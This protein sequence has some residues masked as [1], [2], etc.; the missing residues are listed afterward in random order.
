MGRTPSAML[1][2]GLVL[3]GVGMAGSTQ[4]RSADR[5]G[6]P[7]AAQSPAAFAITNVR[8]FD[9]E[10][11]I[12]RAHVV[13][14]DGRIASA[15]DAAP[16]AGIKAIDGTGHT[17]MPGLIDAHTHAFG[18]ALERA[19]LFG[20]TTELDMFTD[21]SLAAQMRREQKD[22]VVVR[23]ADL[24]SAGTL[25]TAPGGHGTEYGLKIPTI[26]NAAEAAAFV[27][28]RVAE[29]SDYIK[30]VYD[31]R[32]SSAPRFPSINQDA[33]RAVVTAARS[34]NKL[35]VV[36]IGTQRSADHAIA[37][38][39]NGLVHLF[40]D[41]PPAPD[42]AQRMR[43]AGMFAIPTLTVIESTTGTASGASLL[44]DD[45]LA[46]YLT[47][48]E[49]TNLER[50]FPARPSAARILEHAM[51]A[52]RQL[53][54]TGVPLLAGTDAP[55]PGTAHGISIHRELELLVRAGLEPTAA[56]KAA[57]SVPARAFSLVDRG[58]IAAGMRADLVLVEGDPTT[59]ITA[60]R[61]IAGVWKGGVPV[62]RRKAEE[63]AAPDG[64][65]ATGIVSRFEGGQV[66]AEFG[67]GWQVSTDSLMGGK[68]VADMKL[69]P[70][71][72]ESSKG[73]LQ[74]TGTIVEGA[75]YPWAGPM[76]FPAQTPMQP[77]NLARFKE[78][79]FHARGDG[80]EYQVMVFAT[81][82]GNIPA[83]HAFKPGPEWQEVVI[84]FSAFGID[85]S[86]LSGVLFSAGAAAGSFSFAIDEVRF[87]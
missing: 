35:A 21:H 5:S 57:T 20:V 16:P 60:T 14:R 50:G 43:A 46:P 49:R 48:A 84:P 64:G 59:E 32:G 27:D 23:R 63:T 65:T 13:V 42:F 72:A 38:G 47:P 81:R 34:R 73:A 56:L 12:P 10:R 71:G 15:G 80:R 36:H 7:P 52:V 1:V 26:A 11:V 78:I 83:T 6:A 51:T 29:G 58:R 37:A 61:A 55:N 66:D 19:L 44:K 33:L 62:E 28:A 74:V 75:P 68:S 2:T 69:V 31:E 30:I 54:E 40:G 41:A 24:F 67:G 22:G 39:A 53:H 85:G 77:V 8:V 45:R 76:F 87:R 70:G 4:M 86:D 25:V 9:G 17:L 18:D 3:I 82:L 79:V